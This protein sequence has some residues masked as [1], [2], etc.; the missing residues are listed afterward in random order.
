MRHGNLVAIHGIEVINTSVVISYP[1]RNNL[2]PV[3]SIILPFVGR[4][5]LLASEDV[6]IK[7]F[8]QCKIVDGERIMKGTARRGLGESNIFSV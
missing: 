8:C 6:P 1:M 3:E 7:F 2:M 4:A 5:A